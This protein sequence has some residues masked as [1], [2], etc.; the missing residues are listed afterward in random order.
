VNQGES[1][2][3]RDGW[4]NS[5]STVNIG[6]PRM[7]RDCQDRTIRGVK[8]EVNGGVMITGGVDLASTGNTAVVDTD[9]QP[10]RVP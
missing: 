9:L 1:L 6:A 5:V 8:T 3:A 7:S 4:L 10:R 2:V